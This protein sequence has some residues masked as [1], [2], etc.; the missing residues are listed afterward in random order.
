MHVSGRP[1]PDLRHAFELD[2][3]PV[4]GALSGEFRV[5]GRYQRPFG[6]GRM[7]IAA[8][9]A[10]DEAFDTASADLRF[11]GNGV[12]LDTIEMAKS[13]GRVTG[14]AFVGWDG[15]YSFNA[16]ARRI[17]V[18]SLDSMVWPDM[19]F[20]GFVDFSASGSG[21]FDDPRYDVR[22]RVVDFYA[23]DEGIGQV[24]GRLA[25]RGDVL[26]I[27]QLEVAS[28]GLPSRAPDA[29]TSPPAATPT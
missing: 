10:Y 20:T 23:R 1:L 6:F 19:P 16:D 25:V 29:S 12:R 28:P 22:G 3:Y 24:S 27:A 7:T 17:P 14:A 15:T 4:D 5:N 13:T 18:E 11:E 9:R 26:S 21:D 2:D 8:G